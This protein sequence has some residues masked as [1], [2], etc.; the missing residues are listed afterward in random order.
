MEYP[1]VPPAIG[2]VVSKGLA[3]YAELG[4]VLG[5]EDVYAMMEII[6]VDNHNHRPLP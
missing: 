4:T 3:T 1:N 5:T 6:V 2:A